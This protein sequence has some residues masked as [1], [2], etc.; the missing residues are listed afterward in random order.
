MLPHLLLSLLLLLALPYNSFASFYDKSNKGNKEPIEIT[1]NELLVYK[2]LNQVIF[3]GNVKAVQKNITLFSD[4]MVIIYKSNDGT[5]QNE[6]IEKVDAEGNVKIITPN[7]TATSKYAT[8]EA[9][10]GIFKLF[11]EV[12]LLQQGSELFG[13][14]FIYDTKTGK[15][16][17][18]A[19]GAK[20][21]NGRAKAIIIPK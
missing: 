20:N 18:L 2:K 13:D 8:F 12:K 17:L 21:P 1:A 11:D 5:K 9:D 19:N 7:E 16:N 3:I 6:K 14:M 10:N 4:K 15:S